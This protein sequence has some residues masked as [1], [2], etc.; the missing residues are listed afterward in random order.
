M[1]GATDFY[2]PT[3]EEFGPLVNLVGVSLSGLAPVRWEGEGGGESRC[4]SRQL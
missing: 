1:R 2:T 3:A 4:Q